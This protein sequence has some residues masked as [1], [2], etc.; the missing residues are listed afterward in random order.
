LHTRG[1]VTGC[2]LI[3]LLARSEIPN[4]L[5]ELVF[6]YGNL[7]AST[8][9][10]STPFGYAGE[11]TDPTGLIYLRARYYDPA[12]GQFLAIDPNIDTTHQPYLYAGGNPINFTGP[13]GLAWCLLGHN[14]DG[15][16]RGHSIGSAVTPHFPWFTRWRT[17]SLRPHRCVPS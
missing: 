15:S 17:R 9:V 6:A 4:S 7:A 12:T 16:C 10:A 3:R 1:P 2:N 13:T 5:S 8:G 14:P 11:Y